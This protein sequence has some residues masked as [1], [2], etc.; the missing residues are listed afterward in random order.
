LSGQ[1]KIALV[2]PYSL[3]RICGNSLL[4]DR[5]C[6]GFRDRDVDVGLFDCTT[7]Q[8]GEAL[9]FAPALLHSLNADRPDRWVRKFL[10]ESS[11]PWLIT[12]TGTDYNAWCGV[13]APPGH[14]RENLE[15]ADRLV[16]FH[17]E[18]RD[19]LEKHLPTTRGKI[20]VVPQGVSP[21]SGGPQKA[22]MR[23]Q[24]GIGLE[25]IVILMV[26]SIRPVKNL[27]VALEAFTE[28]EEKIPGVVF[29]LIG[30]V[31]DEQEAS[32]ILE[33]GS[34]LKRFVYLGEKNP[35][36]VRSFMAA[37]DVFLNTSHNEGMSGA[38]LEAMV[39]GLP[40]LA[41]DIAG[42]RALIVDGETGILFPPGDVDGLVAWGLKLVE[43]RALRKRLGTAAQRRILERFSP[44]RELDGYEA[45]YREL[46]STAFCPCRP[47]R[48]LS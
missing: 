39:E 32:I 12:L 1:L 28:I 31:L 40:V 9:Q 48:F 46:L 22:D 26:S 37:S 2:S 34:A 47:H 4:A 20:A 18:A 33:Q 15:T 3:P 45:I 13:T 25:E 24:Y 6:R 8:P 5:L 16:V 30:P 21:S 43:D 38:I 36:E 44:E 27:S 42:N 29:V 14:V 19:L 17:G 11:V 23:S 7:E 35:S 10:N 41:S